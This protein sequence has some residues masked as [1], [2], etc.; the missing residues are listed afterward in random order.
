MTKAA[1]VWTDDPV[2]CAACNGYGKPVH[3][4]DGWRVPLHAWGKGGS[5]ACP[6]SLALVPLE[7]KVGQ[8]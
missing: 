1:P 4:A 3:T 2:R 7:G 6:N 8:T 5:V